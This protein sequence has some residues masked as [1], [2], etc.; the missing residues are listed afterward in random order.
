MRTS[1]L[2]FA[3]SAVSFLAACASTTPPA[4]QTIS[5]VPPLDPKVSRVLVAS[6]MYNRGE[7]TSG[8]LTTVRQTGPVYIDGKWA[9]DVAQKESL[10]LD[11]T[12]GVHEIGCSPLEL[13]KN[14]VEKRKVVFEP[15]ETKS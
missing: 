12:P 15:G 14:Y 2:V 11:G 3:V 1:R 7:P 8:T 4:R 5:K 13:V 9:G 10:V 6:G